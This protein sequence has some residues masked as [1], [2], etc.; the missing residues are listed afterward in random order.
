MKLEL[1]ITDE[2]GNEHL[3]N[4]VRSSDGEQNNL[5]DFILKALSISED[6]RKL[7]FLIQCPNGLEVFPSI[8][9]K[10]ENYGNPLL[11]D[12][13]EAMMVTWGD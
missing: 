3:Y 9:M 11:G 12:D 1:K 6:K 5:N 7:P 8:K 2:Q 13:I 4:V 10:F